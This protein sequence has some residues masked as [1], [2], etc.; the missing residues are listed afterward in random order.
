MV[1]QRLLIWPLG[2]ERVLL[3]RSLLAQGTQANP[4]QEFEIPRKFRTKQGLRR[5]SKPITLCEKRR[6]LR[7][8]GFCLM[9]TT[10]SILAKT[11]NQGSYF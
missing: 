2:G 11:A 4:T 9:R 6:F 5:H 1:R 7:N 8:E 3:K 10:S